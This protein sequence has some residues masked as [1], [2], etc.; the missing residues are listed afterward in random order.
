MGRAAE[1]EGSNCFRT[2][3][4]WHTVVHPHEAMNA[5]LLKIVHGVFERFPKV[6]CGYFE[7]ECG[8]VPS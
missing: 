3:T 4:E 6:R 5:M 8:W 7:A 1:T 2:F